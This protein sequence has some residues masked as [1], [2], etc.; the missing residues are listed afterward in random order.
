[1]ITSREF[2][3][4]LTKNMTPKLRYDGKEDYKAWKARA[5]EKL[6]DLLGL[7]IEK[8]KCDNF[9]AEAP[10]IKG[11]LTYIHF[12]FESEDGYY[13]IYTEIDDLSAVTEALQSQG[14]KIDSSD[15]TM[16]P[17][18]YVEV[19]DEEDV[20]MLELLLEKLD[21]DDDVQ[22]VFHNWES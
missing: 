1:M 17:S 10:E 2:I 9:K 12:T 11:D 6:E 19:T 5:K 16:L 3:L 22:N 7:P 13:S 8:A 14:Y 4:N 20:K 21:D 18:T 15:R